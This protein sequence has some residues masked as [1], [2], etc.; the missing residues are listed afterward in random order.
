MMRENQYINLMK[1]VQK[2]GMIDTNNGQLQYV[3]LYKRPIQIGT[4]LWYLVRSWYLISTDVWK[5]Y[6]VYTLTQKG[7]DWEEWQPLIIKNY[8]KVK[9]TRAESE[10]KQLC[11]EYTPPIEPTTIWGQIKHF[12]Y[13]LFK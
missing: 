8:P 6:C 13:M 2:D 3:E 9:K 4:R 10:A 11:Q 5:W 7:I 12:L 1:M